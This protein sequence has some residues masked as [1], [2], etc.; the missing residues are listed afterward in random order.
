MRI[1]HVALWTNKLEEMKDFYVEFF[2][3]T[4]NA[5]Y[6]NLLKNFESYFI[7][8]QSGSRLEIMRNPKIKDLRSEV[9]NYFIGFIH[10]AFSVGS[11]EMVD[12]L[13]LKLQTRGHKIISDPRVTGDGYYESC[14][15]DPDGNKI[16]ITV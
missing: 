5:K 6:N 13:T 8:F 2:N 7:M 9:D 1:E 14:I 10:I 12:E 15:L 4:A 16:E 11:K 3:G